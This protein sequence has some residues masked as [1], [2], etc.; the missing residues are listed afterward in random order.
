MH[1]R[2][3]RGLLDSD[4]R[5]KV[6]LG[7]SFLKVGSTSSSTSSSTKKALYYKGFSLMEL[8][9]TGI[10]KEFVSEKKKVGEVVF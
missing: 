5:A 1:G 8:S 6:E 10:Y 2:L 3:A 7:W 9:G 4:D